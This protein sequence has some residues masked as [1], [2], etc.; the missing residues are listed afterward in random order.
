LIGGIEV[1]EVHHLIVDAADGA[2]DPECLLA[3]TKKQSANLVILD[4]A[5]R[6]DTI[7]EQVI[8]AV[9]LVLVPCQPFASDVRA[10]PRT[11]KQIKSMKK[12][13]QRLCRP[14]LVPGP[15]DPAQGGARRA[16]AVAPR[17][18]GQ[19][20]LLH[21]VR[22]RAERRAAARSTNQTATPPREIGQLF[23]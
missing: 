20:P 23:N 1:P 2:T 7:A 15:G 16:R 4:T 19:A 21:G 6:V 12:K 13:D 22:R 8:F 10:L 9:D 18:V 3:D 17:R 5:G 11:I 14:E